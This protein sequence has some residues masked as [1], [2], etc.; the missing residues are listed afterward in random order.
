MC[1][2]VLT[3]AI[4]V[5][6]IGSSLSS[7][8][9]VDPVEKSGILRVVVSCIL[10][11]C[12][13]RTD[14]L[15]GGVFPGASSSTPQRASV[16]S[17]G[18]VDVDDVGELGVGARASLSLHPPPSVAAMAEMAKALHRLFYQGKHQY[19]DPEL[20]KP[21][22]QREHE[23]RVRYS[24]ALSLLVCLWRVETGGGVPTEEH[25]WLASVYGCLHD[26]AGATDRQLRELILDALRGAGVGDPLPVEV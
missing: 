24:A 8:T 12:D 9:S 16:A 1:F 6:A 25:Q 19:R 22:Q 21:H 4:G 15:R 20:S 5:E 18:G 23:A 17:A 26:L 14:F 10:H 11:A 13:C 3:Q 7:L 2:V